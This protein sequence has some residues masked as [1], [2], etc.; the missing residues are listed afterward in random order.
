M[1]NVMSYL[2]FLLFQWIQSQK[3]NQNYHVTDFF[4]ELQLKASNFSVKFYDRNDIS[5]ALYYL[6][7]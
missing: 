5:A 2:S 1:T 4:S 3:T 7:S 6:S